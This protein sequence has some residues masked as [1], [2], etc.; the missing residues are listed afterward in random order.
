MTPRTIACLY[1]ALLATASFL[2][3]LI[4]AWAD[5]HGDAWWSFPVELFGFLLSVGFAVFTWILIIGSFLMV[6]DGEL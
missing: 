4:A 1:V 2:F 5:F 6:R 3:A